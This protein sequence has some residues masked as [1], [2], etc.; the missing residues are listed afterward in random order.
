[1]AGTLNESDEAKRT[2]IFLLAGGFKAVSTWHRSETLQLCRECCGGQGFA[3]ENRIGTFKSDAEIDLTYEGDNTILMQVDWDNYW[4]VIV[5]ST[6]ISYYPQAVARAL[7]Q[8]FYGSLTGKRRLTNMLN[9]LKGQL[10][11][12]VRSKVLSR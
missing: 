6:H 7:L 5:L 10:G 3:A 8:E 1:M 12:L 11:I 2:E 9:Y 4:S